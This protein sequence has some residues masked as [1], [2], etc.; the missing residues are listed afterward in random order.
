METP[1]IATAAISNNT[2]FMLKKTKFRIF[3]FFV[4]KIFKQIL[5]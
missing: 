1:Q 4:Y 5:R 3:Y 2:F